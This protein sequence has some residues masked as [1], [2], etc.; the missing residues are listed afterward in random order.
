MEA[1][2]TWNGRMT[3]DGTASTGYHVAMDAHPD[4]G[5][6][7]GGFRPLELVA[8]GLAGCTAMDVISILQKKRQDVTDFKVLTH[9]QQAEDHPHVFTHVVLEY[10]ITGKG[11]DP[12]A[13]E[14]AIELSQTRYCSASAML[15]KA[16]PI[17]T[18]YTIIEA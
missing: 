11:V 2:V 17:E 14:R 5:G 15:A 3:L 18:K 8:V 16:T 6:D 9:V 10:I 4:V 7:N 1:S 13:I 12:K